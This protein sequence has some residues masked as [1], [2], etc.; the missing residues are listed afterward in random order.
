MNRNL[1]LG[2]KR[3]DYQ[4]AGMPQQ[5]LRGIYQ[6]LA[7]GSYI[8]KGGNHSQLG[9]EFLFD[10]EELIWCHRMTNTRSHTEVPVLKKLLE[11]A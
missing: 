5:I 10:G 7:S 1:D 2:R 4:I 8:F 3:P 11:N 9:G 6:T